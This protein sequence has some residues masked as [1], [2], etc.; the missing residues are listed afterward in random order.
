M[1][2]Y[3]IRS[4]CAQF[5]VTL[6]RTPFFL[7]GA[8]LVIVLWWGFALLLLPF[9]LIYILFGVLMGITTLNLNYFDRDYHPMFISVFEHS[10]ETL[11]D[12]FNWWMWRS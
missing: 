10:F 9:S 1:G 5:Y 7:V 4:G 3:R 8:F 6:M 12:L 11:K 2:Y